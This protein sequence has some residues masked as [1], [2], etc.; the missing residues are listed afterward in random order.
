MRNFSPLKG[1]TAEG[2]G[3]EAATPTTDPTESPTA[4]PL[5]RLW[6]PRLRDHRISDPTASTEVLDTGHDVQVRPMWHRERLRSL[7]YL[8][9]ELLRSLR[10][11]EPQAPKKK[12]PCTKKNLNRSSDEN[13]TT[14]TAK[15]GKCIVSAANP[16]AKKKSQERSGRMQP[17]LKLSSLPANFLS[18]WRRPVDLRYLWASDPESMRTIVSGLYRDQRKPSCE[19]RES[20]NTKSNCNFVSCD[21]ESFIDQCCFVE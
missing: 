9:W 7:R 3:A 17:G 21:L 14:S 4:I 13:A 20:C 12:K 11:H 1:A 10:W 16:T 15:R 19:D 2:C 5:R 18:G 6:W 8:Q